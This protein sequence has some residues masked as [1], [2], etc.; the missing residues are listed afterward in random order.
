MRIGSDAE[1]HV[2]IL[3]VQDSLDLRSGALIAP[4]IGIGALQDK[5]KLD[6]ASDAREW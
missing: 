6:L 5:V 4:R 2:E 3:A 1:F